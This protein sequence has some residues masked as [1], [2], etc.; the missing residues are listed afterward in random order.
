MKRE[1]GGKENGRCES[2]GEKEGKEGGLLSFYISLLR[3]TITRRGGGKGEK[4]E[5]ERV[6]KGGK[7]CKFWKKR[8]DKHG[9]KEGGNEREIHANYNYLLSNPL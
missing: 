3:G 8:G 9:K 5:G 2:R 4:R 6:R 1:G 7:S